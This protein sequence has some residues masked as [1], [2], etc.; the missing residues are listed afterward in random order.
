MATKQT[1]LSLKKIGDQEEIFVLRAQECIG[2]AQ[3]NSLDRRQ[4]AR[5][6][7]KA[8]GSFECALR[9]R[10]IQTKAAD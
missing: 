10:S 6:D 1:S 3:R 8:A 2:T 4:P 7:D 5:L 9:M